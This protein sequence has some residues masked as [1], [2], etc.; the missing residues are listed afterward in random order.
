MV[1][2]RREST[3]NPTFKKDNKL[4]TA[5]RIGSLNRR[6][7]PQLG[8]YFSSIAE[9]TRS[10]ASKS[11]NGSL[12]THKVTKQAKRQL[13]KLE[14]TMNAFKSYQSSPKIQNKK[15]IDAIQNHE[16]NINS[17]LSVD[18]YRK[19]TGKR[20]RALNQPRTDLKK[21]CYIAN[22]CDFPSKGR[23]FGRVVSGKLFD[24]Q[25]PLPTDKVS[26]NYKKGDK[27][28]HDDE[29]KSIEND[30]DLDTVEAGI[31]L[32]ISEGELDKSEASFDENNED[33][34]NREI[35]EK[36]DCKQKGVND[37]RKLS[38]TKKDDAALEEKTEGNHEEDKNVVESA[39]AKQV[40][41][42]GD[43]VDEEKL[44]NIE[45]EGSGGDKRTISKEDREIDK[46]MFENESLEEMSI[47]VNERES[48]QQRNEV[49]NMDSSSENGE[50]VVKDS[51]EEE[52]KEEERKNVV[53]SESR[54]E[55]EN[56]EEV[57]NEGKLGEGK[58]QADKSEVDNEETM[59]KDESKGGL[60]DSSGSKD[61][62]EDKY[63]GEM[64][65][66][67]S[68]GE[69]DSE[70]DPFSS[71][72]NQ[73]PETTLNASPKIRPKATMSAS[74]KIRPKAT[75]SAS[76][77]IRPEASP[78]ISASLRKKQ[79]LFMKVR[80]FLFLQINLYLLG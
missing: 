70:E 62:L 9:R 38:E 50:L 40:N 31:E 8:M 59:Q 3:I 58:V 26:E 68:D 80:Q 15:D 51:V 41:N 27:I 54:R 65:E 78:K 39:K 47:D 25:T 75:I 57:G 12:Q 77:K 11:N 48:D 73:M 13:N 14:I 45:D 19:N 5:K 66:N 4:N 49:E 55:V 17:I 69:L 43:N 23:N 76:P 34:D 60:D 74:P 52:Y 20:K 22:N 21:K 36:S 71:S 46:N 72:S 33:L 44:N 32:N 67:R 10:Q 18:R 29:M 6:S 24:Q 63:K 28:K 56:A 42:E 7:S 2:P 30:D 61:K 1:D 37:R 79:D 16:A 35:A 53:E 64:E